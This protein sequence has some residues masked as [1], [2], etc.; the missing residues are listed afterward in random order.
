MGTVPFP[1]AP[2]FERDIRGRVMIPAHARPAHHR[3]RRKLA[4]IA[5][6]NETCPWN[7]LIAEEGRRSA[8]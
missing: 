6:W 3:L 8:I 1:L 2:H 4:E 5:A 7:R